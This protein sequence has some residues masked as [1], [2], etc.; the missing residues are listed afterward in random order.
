VIVHKTPV[1][2]AARTYGVPRSTITERLKMHIPYGI[3]K[4]GPAPQLPPEVEEVLVELLIFCARIGYGKSAEEVQ[5][6]VKEIADDMELK[7]CF[8]ENLPS[9]SF[10]YHF[11]EKH[12]DKLSSKG[13]EHHSAGRGAVTKE[14]VKAWFARLYE[15]LKD[16]NCLNLLLDENLKFN[17]DEG[18]FYFN[19]KRG[20]IIYCCRKITFV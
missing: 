14:S 12:K 1:R 3:K 5:D 19:P 11:L 16:L 6:L 9:L 17:M 20:I 13:A 10:V 7:T 18:A 15:V 8:P 2:E 4:Q